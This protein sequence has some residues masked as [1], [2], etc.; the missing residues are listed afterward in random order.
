MSAGQ[1][2]KGEEGKEKKHWGVWAGSRETTYIRIGN[3]K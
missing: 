3:R 1:V 2:D